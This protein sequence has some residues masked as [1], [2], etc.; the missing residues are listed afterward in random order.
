MIECVYCKQNI[1]SVSRFKEHILTQKHI[2][3]LITQKQETALVLNNIQT[4]DNIT[5]TNEPLK[6]ICKHCKRI[7]K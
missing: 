7:S 1:K 4:A 2:T 5:V 3:N 6:Y